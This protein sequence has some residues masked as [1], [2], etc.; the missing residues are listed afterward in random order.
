MKESPTRTELIFM[1]MPFSSIL[2]FSAHSGD[3]VEKNSLSSVTEMVRTASWEHA[4]SIEAVESPRLD[5]GWPV[6]IRLPTQ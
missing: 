6:G 1:D 4:S 3:L 2:G 5:I